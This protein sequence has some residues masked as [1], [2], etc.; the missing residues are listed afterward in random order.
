[1]EDPL[2]LITSKGA[3]VIAVTPEKPENI[4]K[5]IKKTNASFSIIYDNGL[6]IM[7]N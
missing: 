3:T 6:Q 5:T 4:K 1:M 7:K 2:K